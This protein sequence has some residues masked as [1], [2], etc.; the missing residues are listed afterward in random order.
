MWIVFSF[1]IFEMSYRQQPPA[2]N[3]I[4]SLAVAGQPTERRLQKSYFNLIFDLARLSN[5][6]CLIYR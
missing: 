6:F 1:D 5:C 3:K 2:D 4:I